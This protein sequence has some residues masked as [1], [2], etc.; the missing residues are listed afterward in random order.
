MLR[1]PALGDRT[2]FYLANWVIRVLAPYPLQCIAIVACIAM[3]VLLYVSYPVAFTVIFNKAVPEHNHDLLKQI[4]VGILVLFLICGVTAMI[5]AK[6]VSSIGSKGLGSVRQRMFANILEQSPLF[7]SENKA[8]D[9]IAK[10]SLELAAIET[11][12]VFALPPLI[13][14]VLVVI[15]CLLT[16][17]VL[18]WRIALVATALIPLSYLSAVKLGPRVSHYA[19]GKI[20]AES[21]LLAT[22]QDA[23][24]GRNT[25]RAFGV[26]HKINDSFS[27]HNAALQKAS[28]G[29]VFSASLIPLFSLYSVNIILVLMVGTGA[30]FVL[31]QELS[32]GSFFGCLTLLGSVAAGTNSAIKFYAIVMSVQHK[33]MDIERYLEV[34][35]TRTQ[36]K[37]TPMPFVPS[38]RI[39]FKQVSFQYPES[40]L[41][42]NNVSFDIPI[43]SSVAIVG[44]TGSGKSTLIN[45]LTGFYEPTRGSISIDGVDI[46]TIHKSSLRNT[47]GIVFQDAYLL[48]TTIKDN[49]LLGK[50]D[51]SDE[52]VTHAAQKAQIHD[53]IE[54]LPLKYNFMV[55]DNGSKL[56]GGQKQRLAIARAIVRKPN[57]LILDESTSAL[58][59]NTEASIVQDIY[60]LKQNM[61]IIAVTHRLNTIKEFNKIIVLNRGSVVEEGQHFELLQKKGHYFN[62]WTNQMTQKEFY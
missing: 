27:Q 32:L 48:N 16:I 39:N 7:F 59:A 55:E 53:F 21:K 47:C 42:L 30:A 35:S 4:M 5:Q 46:K 10:F 25:I 29:Y 17:S 13:E 37:P 33:V 9:L 57:I 11:A 22:L 31:D 49:I 62:M 18:D 61:T 34:G 40:D 44:E 36:D 1:S 15:G 52:D 41:V 3:Q 2:R 28:S 45:L 24:H 12:L 56:S 54:S 51:A 20:N 43:G 8:S 50:A 23:I 58:D 6:L 60:R 19:I 14:C 26:E 38:E